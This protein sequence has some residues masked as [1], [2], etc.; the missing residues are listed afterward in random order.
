MGYRLYQLGA[1]HAILDRVRKVET[2]LFGI[3]AGDE[4]G[5]GHQASVPGRQL[6]AGPH[7]SEQHVIGHL[8]EE[9]RDLPELALRTGGL[10]FCYQGISSPGMVERR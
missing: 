5:N 8:R 4:C 7:L 2:Q 1:G 9:W 10:L 3:A 6:P